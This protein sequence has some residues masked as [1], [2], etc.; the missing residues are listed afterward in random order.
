MNRRFHRLW[1]AGAVSNLGEGLIMVAGPLAVVS[2]TRNPLHVSGLMVAQQLPTLLFVLLAGAIADRVDRTLLMTAA[3]LTRAVAMG[4]LGFVMAAGNADLFLLYLAFFV[5]AC[6]LTVHDNAF[7]AVL[8]AVVPVAELNKAN[9]RLAAA[10]SVFKIFAAPPLAG[11]LF[12]IAAAAPFL[13]DALSFV[14]VGALVIGVRDRRPS[15]RSSSSIRADIAEGLRWLFRHRML[16]TLA[17]SVFVLNIGLT[18]TMSMLV[19]IASDRFDV[20]PVGYGLL[21]SS[22]AA[23]G[24]A[25]SL[26]AA[27]LVRWMG[28]GNVIRLALVVDVATFVALALGRHAVVAGMAL[29]L[30]GLHSMAFSAT[31]ASLRQMLTPDPLR[32]RVHSAHRLLSTAGAAAGSLL[33]GALATAFTLLTPLWFAAALTTVLIVVTWRS[34]RAEPL[35]APTPDARSP[36]GAT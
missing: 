34:W 8:P 5:A 4:V 30:F 2:F 29:T 33:G 22:L 31:T 23:G 7:A 21:F 24:V 35:A 10:Q 19:L 1:A 9:G 11:W 32:A 6:A 16:R 20:G 12:G 27:T 28:A 13:I 36:R 25:G 18:A 26:L 3:A 15:T 14:L 17:V